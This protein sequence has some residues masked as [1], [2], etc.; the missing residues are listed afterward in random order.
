MLASVNNKKRGV[1]V[2]TATPLGLVIQFD[3]G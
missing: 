1:T 3:Y 2:K